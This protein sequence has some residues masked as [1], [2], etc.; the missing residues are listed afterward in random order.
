MQRSFTLPDTFC[1]FIR[2][3]EAPAPETPPAPTD[4]WPEPAAPAGWQPLPPLYPQ[5]AAWLA[6]RDAFIG[7]I[8]ACR[9]CVTHC[10]KTPRYCPEGERLHKIYDA[11]PYTAA[12]P[13]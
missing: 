9:V 4:I 13:V 7:H 5:P 2:S 6:A 11:T 8:M 3:L 12:S 1:A 10:A